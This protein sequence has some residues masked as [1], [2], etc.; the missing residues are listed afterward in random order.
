MKLT[1]LKLPTSPLTQLHPG[2]QLLLAT[3]VIVLASLAIA[4]QGIIQPLDRREAAL[5]QALETATQQ[6]QLLQ[7]LE[8]VRHDLSQRQAQLPSHMAMPAA[9][10]ELTTLATTHQMTV[11]T[12]VPK[13]SQTIGHYLLTVINV[14]T[15]ATFADT[16]RFLHALSKSNL[17]F[18]V[19]LVELSTLPHSPGHSPT[20]P[21]KSAG[22]QMRLAVGVL[23]V[24]ED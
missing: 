7:A 17:P 11:N 12:I 2:Q 1:D 20:E 15:T 9:L 3:T 21:L 6:A 24:Q 18:R 23:L 8:Q 10:Q 4:H 13:R 19:A 5:R 22:I 14:D 16:L